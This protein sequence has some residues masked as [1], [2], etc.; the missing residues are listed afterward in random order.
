[1]PLVP[2]GE[3]LVRVLGE[4]PFVRAERDLAPGRCVIE[5]DVV[6]LRRFGELGIYSGG[7]GMHQLR[8]VRVEDP[9]RASADAAKVAACG[10]LLPVHPGLIDG[11]VL[12]TLDL[13]GL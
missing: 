3:G 4:V 6:A 2:V 9:E 10:A 8:I 5:H 12:L 13:Q 1:M 7:E 11:Y